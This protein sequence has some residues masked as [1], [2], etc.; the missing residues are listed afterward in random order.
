MALYPGIPTI[1]TNI[2]QQ[3]DGNYMTE[4]IKDGKVVREEPT[5]PSQIRPARITALFRT[6][7]PRD[8][9]FAREVRGTGWRSKQ[10]LDL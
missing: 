6:G 10:Q 7:T 2:V 8:E 4:V 5:H 1:I 3:S 9:T